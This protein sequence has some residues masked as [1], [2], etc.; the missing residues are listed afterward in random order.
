[1]GYKEIMTP[2][3]S[4]PVYFLYG[5]EDYLIQEEI[6]KLLNQT[7]SKKEQGFNF[8]LF[9]GEE[10]SSQEIIQTAQTL[11]MFS[12]YR[13]ILVSDADRMD[14]EKVETLMKYIQKPSRSTCLVLYGQ[15]IGTWKSY[16]EEIEKVGQVKEY[17][18]LR[19]RALASWVRKRMEEKRK[20]LSEDA[21]EYLIETS[22]DH[23]YD[24][25]NALEKVCL[26]VGEKKRI[27]LSD[28]EA[29]SS[30]VKISTVFDLTD[31]IGHQNLEKALGI[32]EKALESGTISFK[33]EEEFTKGDPIPILV[34]MIAKQYWN[35]LLIKQMSSHHPDAGKLAKALG[36][37]PW[38]IKKLMEQGKNFSERS[39]REGIQRCHQTDLDFKKNRGPKSLLMEKLVMDLCRPQG[40]PSEKAGF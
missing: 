6:Q 34:N 27:E 28:V 7:L 16:R 18:R 38:N 12:K 31:A 29:M 32:L 39:L 33:K 8:H 2:H 15:T 5:P 11:P 26:S 10:H 37:S 13:F 30:D 14:E 40:T 17:V 4:Y 23:L 19:G 36:R 1:M 24:I 3:Q 20:L 22:G 9:N 21:A 35:I 25:D